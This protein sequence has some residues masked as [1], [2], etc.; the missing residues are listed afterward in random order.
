MVLISSGLLGTIVLLLPGS[1]LQEVI[2]ANKI[3]M[4]KYCIGFLLIFFV[5]LTAFIQLYLK[6][7]I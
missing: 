5:D 4:I 1:F 6:R 2:M 3:M 7:Y